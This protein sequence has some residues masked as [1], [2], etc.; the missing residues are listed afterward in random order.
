MRER[1]SLPGSTP[2][3]VDCSCARHRRSPTPFRRMRTAARRAVVGRKGGRSVSGRPV[4]R[5]DG[6]QS[7]PSLVSA[8]KRWTSRT[9]PTTPAVIASKIM[10]ADGA[11][12]ANVPFGS[13]PRERCENRDEGCRTGSK[14]ERWYPPRVRRGRGRHSR[15]RGSRGAPRSS[16]RTTPAGKESRRRTGGPAAPPS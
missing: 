10:S 13:S 14:P 2:M 3:G 9:K 5:R 6:C 7:R 16:R 4:G 11:I 12:L 1:K 15:T 8:P